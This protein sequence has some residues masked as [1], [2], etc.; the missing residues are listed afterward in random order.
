MADDHTHDYKELKLFRITKIDNPH[1]TGAAGDKA[2][3][4]RVCHCGKASPM[5]FGAT[6][7]MEQKLEELQ[8]RQ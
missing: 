2:F 4:T 3:L 5:D 1:Y 6:E 7:A 8:A